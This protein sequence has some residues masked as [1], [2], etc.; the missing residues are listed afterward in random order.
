MLVQGR[1]AALAMGQGL[2]RLHGNDAKTRRQSWRGELIAVRRPAPERNAAV[3]CSLRVSELPLPM[4]FVLIAKP[5][6]KPGRL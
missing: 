2:V 6:C 3:E 4:M 1:A 5:A